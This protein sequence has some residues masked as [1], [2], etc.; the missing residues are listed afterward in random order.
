SHVVLTAFDRY[1]L[2]RPKLDELEVRFIP[3]DNAIVANLLAGAIDLTLGPGMSLDEGI[4]VR[5]RWAEGTMSSGVSS[6]INLNPQFLNPDPPV[7]L[8]AQFRRALYMAI[9][10]KRLSDELMFGLSEIADGTIN[11]A[12]VEY[13]YV[14]S[15]IV[16]YPYDPDQ[17]ARIIDDLGFRKGGDGMLVDAAGKPLS[18]QI[19][20]TQDDSNAKPQLAVL[21]S[22]KALGVTPDAEVVTPQRQ[23]DLAYR[24]NFRSFSLQSGIV[25]GADGVNALLSREARLPERNYRGR[26]Y[27]RFM[28]PEIDALVDRYFTTIPFADRMQVL[29]QIIH[30][31]TDNLVWMPLYWRMLP[32]LVNKRVGGV[33]PHGSGNQWW[34]AQLWDV[35]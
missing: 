15:S 26:N 30:Y 25:N 29:S 18:V 17:A 23:R 31:T 22:W 10:R 19:M 1:V 28:N 32:T 3:D 9:D 14:A 11:S 12:E 16:R 21:D 6:V 24:A 35:Q 13:P 34:N 33:Q 8:D 20:A 27:T 5:D 7:L 2:G 4:Q